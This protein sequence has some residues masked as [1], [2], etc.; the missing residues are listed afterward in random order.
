[1]LR[2]KLQ[3]LFKFSAILNLTLVAMLIFGIAPGLIAFAKRHRITP[4]IC[5]STNKREKKK[6]RA[7]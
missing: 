4:T 5:H 3:K 7:E 1:M 6:K 2:Q